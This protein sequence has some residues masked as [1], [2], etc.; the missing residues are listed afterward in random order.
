MRL[1]ILANYFCERKARKSKDFDPEIRAIPAF[2]D[3]LL[4]ENLDLIVVN[5]LVSLHDE[6]AT[7]CFK[8]GKYVWVE[9]PFTAFW[10]QAQE[11]IKLVART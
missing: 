9:K 11:L 8:A 1:S 6:Q 7:K 2:K 5:T 4:D 10:A 3:L